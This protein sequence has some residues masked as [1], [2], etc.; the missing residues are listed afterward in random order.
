MSILL[1]KAEPNSYTQRKAL[2]YETRTFN[3]EVTALTFTYTHKQTL[4]QRLSRTT[5]KIVTMGCD[6]SW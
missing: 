2:V 6:R 1:L 4:D 5:I 3:G